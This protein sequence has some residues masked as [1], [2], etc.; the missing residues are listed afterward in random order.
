M[1]AI[2][3]IISVLYRLYYSYTR[4]FG[5]STAKFYR[6]LAAVWQPILRC[7]PTNEE[8]L[9]SNVYEVTDANVGNN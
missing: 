7:T 2:D 4:I 1:L 6:T 8:V 9:A 5:S 3:Q